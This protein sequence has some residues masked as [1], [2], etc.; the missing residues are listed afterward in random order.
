MRVRG[1][2]QLHRARPRIHA[3]LLAFALVSVAFGGVMFAPGPDAFSGKLADF[4][5]GCDVSLPVGLCPGDLPHPRKRTRRSKPP[6]TWT[7]N[8]RQLRGAAPVRLKLLALLGVPGLVK[9][10]EQV[11]HAPASIFSR[12]HHEMIFAFFRGR[13]GRRPASLPPRSTPSSAI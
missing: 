4:R 12:C 13:P 7:G 1:D 6:D 3:G 2:L 11:V 5:S 9:P 8:Q 10:S